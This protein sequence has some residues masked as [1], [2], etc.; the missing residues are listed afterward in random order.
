M[1]WDAFWT[2]WMFLTRFPGPTVPFSPLHLQRACAYFPWVGAIL[3]IGLGCVFWAASYLWNPWIAAG[4]VIACEIWWTGAFHHDGFADTCD[5]YGGGWTKERVLE[6]LKDS[7]L[8][9]FAASGLFVL[10]TLKLTLLATLDP[11]EGF[12]ALMILQGIARWTPLGVMWKMPYGGDVEHSKAKPLALGLS[13]SDFLIATLGA[14]GLWTLSVVCFSW[15]STFIPFALGLT[16][17]YFRRLVRKW[18]QGYTGDS[19]GASEQVSE[20]LIL[21]CLCA[22]VSPTGN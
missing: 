11:L 4:L 3:G 5:G 2:A 15:K 22:S 6:I 10:L 16:V 8:G 19:L 20:V 9:S 18:T 21:L 13:R 14:L 17:I 1:P 12:F 7:R